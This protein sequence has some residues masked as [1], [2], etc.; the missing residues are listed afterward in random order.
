[1]PLPAASRV[2]FTADLTICRILNG[3]WQVSGAH[4]ASTRRARSKRCSPT[5]MPGSPPG[6][7]PTITAPP[8]TSSANSA[9]DCRRRR[10]P[11]SRDSG[12]HEVGATPGPDDEARRRGAIG[13]RCARMGVERSTCSSSTGGTT[14]TKRYLDALDHLADLQRGGQDPPPGA[15]QLRHRAP[16]RHRRARHPRRLEPGA[17][18]A[19]RPPPGGADGASA[20]TI[21][22]TLLAY[23]TLLGGLLSERISAARS[24]GRS[25]LDTAS[26]RKY[27][28]MIDAWGGWPLFQELLA[29]LNKSPTNT[30]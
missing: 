3:M 18:L 11:A 26:L 1:M 8:K 15:D 20:A 22:I 9:G 21:A 10:G 13:S 6:T 25:E 19:R 16:Q 14:A 17:V 23:G 5:T 30:G 28:Q 7:S 24:R 2:Q 12:L 27:K 29:V 4:G